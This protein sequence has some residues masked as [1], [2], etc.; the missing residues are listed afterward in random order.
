MVT[1]FP[2]LLIFSLLAPFIIRL[3]LGFYFIV[4]GWS[5]IRKKDD[6]Q[7]NT[8]LKQVLGLVGL[9]GGLFVLV[10]A[11]TQIAA[12]VLLGL[13]AYLI[14]TSRNRLPYI[15][16]LGMALSLLLSGAGLLAFDL[17]L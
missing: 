17:P 10:G 16:L 13:L 7:S 4:W 1:I 9:V 14:K 12:L 2:D 8:R 15:L 11:F 5:S 3:F 6:A